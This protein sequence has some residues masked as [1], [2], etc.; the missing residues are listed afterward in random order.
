MFNQIVLIG[1]LAET[2]DGSEFD[3]FSFAA[4]FNLSGDARLSRSSAPGWVARQ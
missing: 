3:V 1:D 4:A 2:A